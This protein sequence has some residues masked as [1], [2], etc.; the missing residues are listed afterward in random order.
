MAGVVSTRRFSTFPGTG[1]SNGFCLLTM[2]A[3]RRERLFCFTLT[4]TASQSFA[5]GEVT[6]LA[7][8]MR[9]EQNLNL[10]PQLLPLTMMR[11]CELESESLRWLLALQGDDWMAWWRGDEWDAV[12]SD[13]ACMV[14][15]NGALYARSVLN[16]PPPH[17]SK[18]SRTL[19]S[20]PQTRHSPLHSIPMY[21]HSDDECKSPEDRGEMSSQVVEDFVMDLVP[22]AVMGHELCSQ[23][24]TK[25]KIPEH[26]DESLSVSRD[27]DTASLEHPEGSLPALQVKI[28]K[29][30]RNKSVQS[31]SSGSTPCTTAVIDDT[32]VS[33]LGIG[34]SSS[35][36]R[37]S[38]E[39]EYDTR[40]RKVLLA[41]FESRKFSKFSKAVSSRTRSQD[42]E[43]SFARRQ[44]RPE[45]QYS[46]PSTCSLLEFLHPFVSGRH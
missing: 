25:A 2:D 10:A 12:G 32:D 26:P 38:A 31:A 20:F 22:S 42:H 13:G 16:L 37:G 24:Q 29:R 9:S 4:L 23:F 30:R 34:R 8:A 27:H 3:L 36:K 6:I 39:R 33:A 7:S 21:T 46:D 17:N 1:R 18:P 40:L 41:V 19:G 43:Y 11:L 15:W 45:S 35:D 14:W 28:E 5:Y 44:G